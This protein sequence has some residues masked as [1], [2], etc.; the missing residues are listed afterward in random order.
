MT[1][2][3][4][5]ARRRRS[6]R[7]ILLRGT[8]PFVDAGIANVALDLALAWG[9]YFLKPTQPRLAMLRP[10][11][12][13]HELDAYDASARK[14]MTLAFELVASS[15]HCERAHLAAVVRRQFPWV[16][17]ANLGRLHSQGQ[18]FAMK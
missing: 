12:S 14:V 13:P 8:I 15:P 7:V 3:S 18:Y 17:D 10:E 11:L 6:L 4:E 1:S 5:R 2:P 16:D 9:E